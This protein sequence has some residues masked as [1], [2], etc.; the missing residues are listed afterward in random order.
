[1]PFYFADVEF[2]TPAGRVKDSTFAMGDLQFEPLLL[3]WHFKRLDIGAG[4]AFWAPT[5]DY[6]R[7]GT[8]PARI[9][10]KGFW[11][12]MLTLGATW[13][14]DQ[15]KTW[16]ISALNRYEIHLENSDN[17][18]TAGDTDTLEIGVS[19]TLGK[20]Y[21]VGVAGYYQK[22][23]TDY[24]PASAG[25]IDHVLGFGPEISTFCPKLGL[26]SSLRY[27][28]EFDAKDRPEGHTVSLTLTKRW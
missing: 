20:F 17:D 11:S 2:D 28:Y 23:T 15:G 21:D 27:L 13:Y 12:H 19:K 14:A 6:N 8:R 25:P 16:A 18:F 1:V 22:Q 4:Y 5:G 24:S 26:F 10:A 9:L 3:A 7:Y